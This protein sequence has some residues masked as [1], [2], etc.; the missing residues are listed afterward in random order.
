MPRRSTIST[1]SRETREQLD[2][3]LRKTKYT[4][5]SDVSDWLLRAHGINLGKSAVGVYSKALKAKD[6]EQLSM[7]KDLTA[8]LADRTVSDLLVELGALRVREYCIVKRLE[9][10]GFVEKQSYEHATSSYSE[11]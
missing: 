3:K 1:L 7:A 4:G 2:A 10:I 11:L 9:S 6:R 8:N 5:L